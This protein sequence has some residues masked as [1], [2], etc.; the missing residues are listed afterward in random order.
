MRGELTLVIRHVSARVCPNCGE[1]YVEEA[2]AAR[3][4]IT[5]EQLAW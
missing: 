2:I 4:L 3:L 1:E 5:A